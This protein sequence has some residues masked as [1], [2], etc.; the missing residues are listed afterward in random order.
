MD[1]E[2]QSAAREYLE[3]RGVDDDMAEFL[4]EYMA[5]KDRA[6]LVSWLK[7]VKSFVRR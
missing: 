6:E 1:D 2:L 5:N 4:H 3:E 7:N